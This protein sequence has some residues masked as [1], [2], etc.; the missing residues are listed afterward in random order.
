MITVVFWISGVF[1]LLQ[2]VLLTY[3][4]FSKQK[5]IRK[6][7]E[8][9]QVYHRVLN[10]YLA[11]LSGEGDQ[12]PDLP[13]NEETRIS[14]IEKL[15]SGYVSNIKSTGDEKRLKHTA[16]KHLSEYYRDILNKGS[17]AERVNALYYIEDFR[18]DL[19]QSEVKRHFHSLKERDEEY[20]QS[21]RVLASF[22]EKA[23][24]QLL[25]S[26]DTFS[27]GFIKELLRRLPAD[28][29]EELKKEKDIPVFF[30]IGMISYFGETGY[31]EHLPYVEHHITHS[32]KEVRLKALAAL[33]Q[34]RYISSA[35][36]LAPFL[37]SE[38]W[39]ERMYGARLSGILQLTRY[40]TTLMKLAG[41]SKWWVRFAACEALKQMP[42][43]EILLTFAAEG[44]EDLY[45][46]DM[47]RQLQTLKTGVSR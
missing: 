42:D 25:K 29:L 14:V 12:E 28:L 46:R 37:T 2:V 5:V 44:H 7:N 35:D 38:L 11:Y 24:I 22:G 45:A 20:R 23:L 32:E 18:M 10:P 21:L 16:E 27:T 26:D 41:D 8:V 1:L 34:Y 19:L 6:D 36:K 33:C 9:E 43:G 39:E 30:Q 31:Y 4:S 15:L 3:L 13:S 17:W 40:S 47:A